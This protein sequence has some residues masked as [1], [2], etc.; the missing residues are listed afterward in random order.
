M[1]GAVEKRLALSGAPSG[2]EPAPGGGAGSDTARLAPKKIS[3]VWDERSERPATLI[4]L[5]LTFFVGSNLR[6]WACHKRT[7]QGQHACITLLSLWSSPSSGQRGESGPVLSSR[8][9]HIR[10]LFG[11]PAGLPHLASFGSDRLVL[12]PL[13]EPPMTAPDRSIVQRKSAVF[14]YRPET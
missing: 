9:T 2:L 13:R 5:P 7:P 4:V 3:C 12:Y 8:V 11:A 10:I 14:G 6:K 1:E